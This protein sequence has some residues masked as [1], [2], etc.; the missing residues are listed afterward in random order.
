MTKQLRC[1]KVNCM[2]DEHP[3][4][5]HTWF[6]EQVAAIGWPPPQFACRSQP[7]T[8][9]GEWREIVFSGSNRMTKL[10]SS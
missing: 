8:A 2:E 10:L 4:L 1:W 5:W 3:G 6:T 7:G 9:L